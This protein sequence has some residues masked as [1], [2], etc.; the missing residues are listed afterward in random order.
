MDKILRLTLAAFVLAVLISPINASA[1]TPAPQIQ[2]IEKNVQGFIA[3]QRD[4][5]AIAEKMQGAVFLNQSDAKYR[6]EREVVAK[7]YG[8]RDFAEYEAVA[9]NISL[10]LTAID[11]NTK[12]YA[13]P[14]TAI[15]KEIEDVKSDKT[16]P[17][18]EKKQLLAELDEALKS[19]ASIQ[20]PGNIELVKKYYDKIDVTTIPANEGDDRPNSRIV[21]TISE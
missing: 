16:I 15:K 14:Q 21:R 10:V 9:N 7:K 2:L 5:S 4:M 6:T 12:E 18:R 3:A 1:Q 19:V 20:F 13:D 17:N 11:P 8:F